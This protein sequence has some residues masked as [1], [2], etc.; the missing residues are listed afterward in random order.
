MTNRIEQVVAILYHKI[1][2]SDFTNMYGVKKPKKGGGQ[3]YIQA[4]GYKPN[5]LDEMFNDA[6]SVDTPEFWDNER[7]YP[8]KKYK[9][10]TRAVGSEKGGYIELAPRTGRKDYRISRQTPKDRHP[11]WSQSNGFP[12]PDMDRDG[13]Y[14]YVKNYPN[15]IKNLYIMIIKT[16]AAHQ[17]VRYYA[18]YI[19]AKTIPENWPKSVGLEAIFT[20]QSQG[21]LFY[22]EQYLRFKND[23]TNPF[24]P[25]SAID[26]QIEGVL[27]PRSISN[28]TDDAVEFA[29]KELDLSM[30]ITRADLIQVSPPTGKR[31]AQ[32]KNNRDIVKDMDF[33][34]RQRNLKKVGDLGE[35][36]VLDMEKRNLVKTGRNDLADRVIHVSKTIGDGVG[37]DIQSFD[38]IGDL[39]Y[40]KYIEVKA[41]TGGKSKPFDI[42][43]N[44]VEI[45]AE[46]KESYSI[47]RLFGLGSGNRK[48]KYYEVK[49][50]IA[51][52]FN[53][54]PTGYK[55]YI[56]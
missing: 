56:K 32:S 30:D 40:E 12:A 11:A 29:A 52:K 20:G 28:S 41:T 9:F 19:D 4:A 7:M 15:K 10:Y 16:T 39:V 21:I 1:Q 2:D 34:R 25:G 8:R 5:E 23:K 3:T 13:E 43:A 45:S 33:E 14:V 24:T 31:R 26:T 38:V 36:L 53:L 17:D 47:Y 46:K 55:A 18:S 49:G 27:L 22:E 42:S 50:S 44:E 37:Y 48:V 35:A 51:E 6:V 54:T